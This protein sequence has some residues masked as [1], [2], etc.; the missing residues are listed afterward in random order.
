MS[1]EHSR[2]TSSPCFQ[3]VVIRTKF[4]SVNGR[5]VNV[6]GTMEDLQGETL[7]MAQAMFVEPSYAKY[8]S[9]SGVAAALG[10]RPEI[11]DTAGRLKDEKKVDA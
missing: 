9:N 11:L 6:S 8:L 4:D 10:R 7:A 5:K 3:F 2:L 1:S